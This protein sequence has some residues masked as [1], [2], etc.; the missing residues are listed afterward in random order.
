MTKFEV[1]VC[2]N[3]YNYKLGNTLQ[4]WLKDGICVITLPTL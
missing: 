3:I 1:Q 2:K 4:Y